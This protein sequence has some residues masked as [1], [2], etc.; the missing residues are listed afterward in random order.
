MRLSLVLSSLLIASPALAQS[1][2]LE[3]VFLDVGQGDATLIISPSGQTM[4]VDAGLEKRGKDV[5][6]PYLEGRDIAEL[7]YVCASHYH[8]DHLGGLDEVAR[9]GIVVHE[10]IDRGD[11]D[12]PT[13]SQPFLDYR[14]TYAGKRRTIQAGE[15]IDLGAGVT[16]TCIVV[17]GAM[18]NGTS[19]VLSGS[20][21]QENSASIG[22]LLEYGDFDMF[23]GG[24]L[25]GPSSASVNIELP[26]SR[27]CGDVDVYRVNFHGSGASSSNAALNQL[28]PEFAVISVASPNA[29]NFPRAS[30]LARL[31]HPDRAIAVWCTSSGNG[32]AGF[33]DCL[34][35]ISLTTDG[36]SYTASRGDGQFLRAWCDEVE[37]VPYPERGVLI[38]EVHRDPATSNDAHGE[39]LE[40]VGTMPPAPVGLR[41]TRVQS[42]I[43]EEFIFGINLRI[44]AGERVVLAADGIPMRNGNYQPTF[45]WPEAAISLPDQQATLSILAP[46]GKIIDQVAYSSAWP[47]GSGVSFERVDCLGASEVAN[48]V[49]ST[50]S[51]GDGDLGTPGKPNSTEVTDWYPGGYCWMEYLTPPFLDSALQLRMTLPGEAGTTFRAALSLGTEPGINYRG[52]NIPINDGQLFDLSSATSG[53]AGQVPADEVVQLNFHLPF[54]ASLMNQT[55]YA[56]GVTVNPSNGSLR[57]WTRPVGMEILP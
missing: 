45:A 2:E 18:S 7:D 22:W 19:M 51:Y 49:A 31:T 30:T 17:N 9:N 40:L 8:T 15:V 37:T 21:Q 56:L 11:V 53:W 57:T 33:V 32:G 42:A 55:I 10:A 28:Q 16:M 47:G 44:D 27:L 39:W 4:L 35:H 12:A 3:V 24:D 48:F 26:V 23:V 13:T 52:T 5:I 25:T 29:S 14:Q 38:S 54:H 36:R 46:D 41:G 43:G 6:V 34:G 20:G 50:M 1:G